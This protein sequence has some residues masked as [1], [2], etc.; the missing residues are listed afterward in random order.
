MTLRTLIAWLVVLSSFLL[1]TFAGADNAMVL[2][3]RLAHPVM[4]DGETQRNYL[5]IGLNGCRPERNEHRT[6]VNVAFVIDRS[7]SMQ[8]D[9]I[10]Q[11]L[12]AAVVAVNRLDE[13]DIASVVTF[14]GTVEVLIPARKVSDRRY[15]SDRIRQIGTRGS[16][17]IYDAVIGGAQEVRTF[18]D[19]Q[20][21]NR[22]VL[23]SDG[24]TNVGPRQ[25]EYF[26][27]LGR[28]LL[29]EG[30]SV[31]TIGLGSGY[32]ED[33]MLQLARASDGNHA[34]ASGATDLIQIFNREFDD[35]LASCAQTVSI[36]VELRPGVRVVRA[37]SRDGAIQGH[38]A[39]FRLNQIYAATE[40]YVLLELEADGKQAADVEDFGRVQVAYTVPQ[41]G[42]RQTITAAIRGRLSQSP[43][44]VNASRDDTVLESV[45]E[46]TTRER[47]Q[48]AV[49]LRDQGKGDEARKLFEQNVSDI[50]AYLKVKP[51]A[52]LQDLGKQYGVFANPALAAS[53][54]QWNLQ[55]KELRSLD[56]GA[57]GAAVR[58]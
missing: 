20:R 47:A 18:K 51:S 34:F 16:T 37:L 39:Q 53:P 3:A 5:R 49:A 9:R 19:A 58:Y 46:Q 28:D 31:S 7:G 15:F 44:E 27:K 32:N 54:S 57:A 35:V 12:D 24:Q 8:G 40:H 11:A 10:A 30:I 4:K 2:E 36:D 26:A 52:R 41:T 48:Q 38:N 17:A 13:N 1:P 56:T 55:R 43:D 45:L 50:H 22:V 33:L 42:A 25:A 6:P 21:L 23:L 14:D 29:S